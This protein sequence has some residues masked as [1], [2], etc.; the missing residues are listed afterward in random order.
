MDAKL[1]P[2]SDRNLEEKVGPPGLV[3]ELAGILSDSR[4]EVDK[5]PEDNKDPKD[6]YAEYLVQKY[7]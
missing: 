4:V 7:S 3:T 5:D 1:P 2:K 6:D